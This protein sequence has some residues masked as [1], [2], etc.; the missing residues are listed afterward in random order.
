M[1]R[2]FFAALIVMLVPD[3]SFGDVFDRYTNPILSKVP[4][5]S[6]VK[7]VKRLTPELVAEHNKLLPGSEGALVV[8]KTNNGLNAKL[9]VQLA[10]QRAGADTVPIL[11][12]ERFV[13]YR[14]GQERV[15]AASGQ[16]LHLYGGFF[17]NL[18][19]GQVVPEKVGADLRL[20]VENEQPYLEP[21]GKAR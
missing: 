1:Q 12:V 9:I 10:R 7:E 5:A 8:V 17:Y 18:E 16:N 21:V 19:I 14:A 4:D 15:V 20:V 11:L 6:G 3:F 2:L 13:T